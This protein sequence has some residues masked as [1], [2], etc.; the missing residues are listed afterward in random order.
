MK[1]ALARKRI[2]EGVEEGNLDGGSQSASWKRT[3]SGEGSSEVPSMPSP[4]QNEGHRER[5]R[6]TGGRR[7]TRMDESRTMQPLSEFNARAEE[8]SNGT[9]VSRH[10][11]QRKRLEKSFTMEPLS[12]YE[13]RLA[14]AE[15]ATRTTHTR[16]R[17]T[18]NDALT[19]PD[20]ALQEEDEEDEWNEDMGELSDELAVISRTVKF[21]N[22]SVIPEPLCYILGK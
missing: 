19:Q 18:A 12:Q 10:A 15:E 20:E 7:E 14:A 2:A 22:S 16:G 8:R 5:P 9:R 11:H 17:D 3:F 13:A 1:R 6:P 21:R 4:I